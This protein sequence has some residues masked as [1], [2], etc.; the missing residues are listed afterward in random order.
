MR[1]AAVV[2][3]L[4]LRDMRSRWRVMAALGVMVALTVG[5][6]VLLD[7]YVNSTEVRFR[8]AQS[9]LVVQQQGTVGEFAG[10][11]IP[12][13]VGEMLR[14]EGYDPVAEGH[15]VAGASGADA[16]MIAGVEPDRYRQ[17]DPYRLVSGRHLRAGETQ[18]TA[19]VGTLLADRRGLRPGDVLRL[20]GRDFAIVGVFELGIY[21]DDAAIVPIGDAQTLLGW[22]SD[23]SV[24]V[25][26]EGGALADGTLLDGGLA[27]AT[28]GDIA[29]V[30]EW[31]P[32]IALLVA[33]VRLLALGAV[34]VLVI[35]LWRLAWLHRIDLGVL[36]LLGFGRRVVAAFLGVQAAVLV[37]TAAFLGGAGAVFIAP[38]LARTSLA[39][40]TM[41]VVDGTVLWRAAAVGAAVLAAAVAT[42]VLAVQR[43]SVGDLI[44][45][46]D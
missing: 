12:A 4:A 14:A 25:V 15:A 24:Y 42:S 40:A 32:M 17:L 21:L 39:V 45:R 5:M 13:S 27:V 33:S 36:R 10:S 1:A 30:G 23:V 7:G 44:H 18:R 35:A 22:G 8:H 26:P 2:V 11:R 31:E 37:A 41:P 28:R 9:A 46:D 19:I 6:V 34:A 43:R 3:G 20:R 16:V 38:Y 29:L